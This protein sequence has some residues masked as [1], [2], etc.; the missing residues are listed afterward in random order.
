MRRWELNLALDPNGA[1]PLSI[2]LSTIIAEEIRRGRLSPGEPL[3]SSRELAARL[4]ASRNTVMAAY[5]ELF[6]EGLV[7]AQRGGGTFV[8]E[9]EAKVERVPPA[10]AALGYSL[11]TPIALVPPSRAPRPG[12]LSLVA[13]PDPRLFPSRAL[14]RAFGNAIAPRVLSRLAHADPR[15]HPALRA[16]LASMV[17]R[18]RGFALSPD[19]VLITRG[20]VQGIDFAARALLQPGDVVAVEALGY[21]PAWNALRL[22][23]ARL[24]PVP[25]D[26][27]GLDVGALE[28]LASRE[29]L[30]AVL[31][32]P[33][34]QF[35]TS[36]VMRPARRAR[37]AALAARRRF[38]ILE[39]D[40][41]H[42]FHYE[43]K[44]LPPIAASAGFSN[45]IYIGS[46]ANVLPPG[47]SVGF[48]LAPPSVLEPFVGL[49]LA[50][51]AQGDAAVECAIAELFE[52][53]E[54]VRHARRMRRIYAARR[55]ALVAALDR[56]LR[57]ALQFEVPDG[58]MAIWARV[59]PSIDLAEWVSAGESSG[60]LFAPSQRYAFQGQPPPF[61]RLGFTS[62]D[63]SEL[64]EAVRRM[65]T[66]LGRLRRDRK[67]GSG[68]CAPADAG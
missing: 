33:H 35:P 9:R 63:E 10:A 58:G 62:L 52:E 22:A 54:M 19:F 49:R 44:P 61:L 13:E 57:V 29:P 3:P 16:E 56:Y 15:G 64:A 59:D 60:V 1:Q 36:A 12:A 66:A 23:G 67:S 17:S 6:A 53:G 65:E 55:D 50:S 34:H 46:L 30:R 8:A 51:A 11:S 14:A 32:T 38:V 42:E 37:L 2:Q 41:D 45:A 40:D 48:V 4:G 26:A 5:D 21:P 39:D 20:I 43:G 68:S 25:L 31:V 27:E 28:A 47:I 18:T 7:R 24:V